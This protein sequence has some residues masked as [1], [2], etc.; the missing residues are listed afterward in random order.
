MNIYIYTR[1][2]IAPWVLKYVG[3]A[4]TADIR[5]HLEN[6]I[7]IEPQLARHGYNRPCS[8]MTFLSTMRSTVKWKR[9]N[10][11]FNGHSIYVSSTGY[12]SRRI[13]S[14]RCR[15]EMHIWTGRDM[16]A[17]KMWTCATRVK[18]AWNCRKN[19]IS[20]HQIWSYNVCLIFFFFWIGRY[21]YDSHILQRVDCYVKF[22]FKLNA[23]DD[24][25]AFGAMRFR[26][27]SNEIN[28]HS[29]NSNLFI[30]CD[31]LAVGH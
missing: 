10:V 25:M 16:K 22:N 20:R 12:E 31:D 24:V 15:E 23:M 7:A 26:T 9:S 1:C 4:A 11:F 14:C 29:F 6:R 27:I 8:W 3:S 17:T 28:A 19:E 21:F 30:V 2:V 5:L 13:W 18:C